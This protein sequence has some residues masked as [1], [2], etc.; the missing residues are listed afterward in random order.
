MPS[1]SARV[2][3]GRTARRWRTPRASSQASA[4]AVVCTED[5][6]HTTSPAGRATPGQSIEV[7]LPA[8]AR[9]RPVDEHVELLPHEQWHVVSFNAINDLKHARVD[10][11]GAVA[12]Q[13]SFWQDEWLEAHELQRRFQFRVATDV[14]H[15]VRALAYAPRLVLVDVDANM[16]RLRSAQQNQRIR[17]RSGRRELTHPHL[18]L[19]DFCSQ[20]RADDAA[21]EVYL[22]G[23]H[24]GFCGGDLT[25]DLFEFRTRGFDRGPTTRELL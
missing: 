5:R 7:S 13:R 16:E 12:R 2:S 18:H 25:S 20:R 19:Q 21:F 3:T 23:L 9:A 14:A 24:V 6:Q 17:R 4:T 15:G 11:L 22:H 8:S 10:T 1:T